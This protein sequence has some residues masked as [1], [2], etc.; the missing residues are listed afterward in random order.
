MNTR[1][2]LLFGAVWASLALGA[3]VSRAEEKSAA[4]LIAALKSADEPGRLQAIDQLGA[5]GDKAAT[6]VAPLTELLKDP[7]AKV[8]AHAARALGAIGAPAKSAVPALA[9]LLKDPDEMV[10]RQVVKAVLKIRPGPQVT[11]P[12]CVKLLEDPDPGVRNRILQAITEAGPQAVPALI[13]ALKNDK[14]A[15]WAC[16][17]L[18]EMGPA[19]KA[20]VPALAE[21]LKDPRPGIRREAILTLGAMNEAAIPVL[22][23]IA[24]CLNDEHTRVAATFVLGELGQISPD[25]ET[26]IRANA[27]SND[28]FLSS[29][30][31]WALARVHPEDK[32]LRREATEQLIAR[33]KDPEAF[34]RVAAAR[35][36]AAL[37][38]APEITGPIW[39]KALQN[40]DEVT[41]R[42]ALD[43]LAALGAPAVPRLIEA[44]KHEHLRGQVVYI[45]GQIGPAAAPAAE[46]LAGLVNDK[47]AR[48]AQEAAL[49]LAKIGPGAKAAMPALVKS[50][51]QADG[52]NAHAVA[53]ALGKI[54]PDA[55]AQKALT[56]LLKSSDRDLALVSAWV[57]AQVRPVTPELAAQTVPVLTA[58]LAA[59]LPLERQSAAEA[60]GNLGPLA[61]NATTLAALQKAASDDDRAVRD[62]AADALKAIQ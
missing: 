32:Q 23:Q 60:L 41:A 39:Q 15:Y 18:R 62:A 34:V 13:E 11:V 55:A 36:L 61:K 19:A 26:A 10:R 52:S 35:A 25:A 20:A 58:G 40:A 12:L 54:G 43:A 42:H 49:A 30:S 53:Y 31:L 45:L 57:L 5:L 50:L 48:V 56:G 21:K 7:S 6:A 47:N 1:T 8:R 9:D 24:A 17:V 2:W 51:E 33:L 29:V 16:L 38:P 37:P 3:L 22:P 28:A 59:P 4:D 44:L 27:K 14:A 46:A